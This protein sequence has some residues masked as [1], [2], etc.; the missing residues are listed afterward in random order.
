VTAQTVVARRT[1]IGGRIETE[2]TVLVEGRVEGS[3]RA[4]DTVVIAQSGLVIAEVEGGTVEVR[5]IVIGNITA[6]RRIAV[7]PGARVVGDLRGPEIAVAADATVEGK[8]DRTGGARTPKAPSAREPRPTL[9]LRPPT[10]H[11]VAPAEA[12]T[13]P[14][15][16]EPIPGIPRLKTRARIVT[17]RR[18]HPRI[19]RK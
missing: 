12:P 15:P 17:P 2:G 9:R 10:L 16:A 7:T 3:I 19:V 8:I 14:G 11:P 13:D 1:K 4:A 6:T 18:E 5:G